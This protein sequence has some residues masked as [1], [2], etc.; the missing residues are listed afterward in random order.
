[1]VGFCPV[2]TATPDPAVTPYK[3]LLAVRRP[4]PR[5]RFCC[6]AVI[7]PLK[8]VGTEI[9]RT[10]WPALAA[11]ARTLALF[12][13][14][15]L[16][17][18]AWRPKIL[19]AWPSRLELTSFVCG[20]GNPWD[21]RKPLTGE[22]NKNPAVII[23]AVARATVPRKKEVALGMAGASAKISNSFAGLKEFSSLK[24]L[25]L[26]TGAAGTLGLS[27]A[28]KMFFRE[29]CDFLAETF[30]LCRRMRAV[31]RAE[32]KRLP[33]SFLV[34]SII[35]SCSQRRIVEAETPTRSASCDGVKVYS[36][37]LY[38]VGF[39]MGSPSLSK[40]ATKVCKKVTR[41]SRGY[42]VVL[43]NLDNLDYL[44]YPEAKNINLHFNEELRKV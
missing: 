25:T 26:F 30:S 35:P 41:L 33:L 18:V 21:L 19:A 3:T 38:L 5:S 43:I 24:L 29:V 4:L 34:E 7:E 31:S 16:L 1:M 44:N 42:L 9:F 6:K 37:S 36:F 15:V 27:T 11:A 2:L 17:V 32:Y 12:P 10:V 28:A 20:R 23:K 22:V 14:L 8:T 39:V 13:L 40:L